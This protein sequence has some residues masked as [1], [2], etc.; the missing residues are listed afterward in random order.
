ME[1]FLH[2]GYLRYGRSMVS[3]AINVVAWW[4][5][6]EDIVVCKMSQDVGGEKKESDTLAWMFS[7][8]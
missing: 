5:F 6:G 1:P 8:V 2:D 3:P 4:C 7:R